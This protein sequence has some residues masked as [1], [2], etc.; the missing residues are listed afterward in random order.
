MSG[1][2][3]ACLLLKIT[4]D[5]KLSKRNAFFEA[6]LNENIVLSRKNYVLRQDLALPQKKSAKQDDKLCKC[7]A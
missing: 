7:N 2:A 1:R 5:D 6:F 3:T 4:Q